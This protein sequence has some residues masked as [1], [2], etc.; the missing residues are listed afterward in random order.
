MVLRNP[1]ANS[2]RH[3]NISLTRVAHKHA[4]PPPTQPTT[5]QCNQPVERKFVPHPL[6]NRSPYQW[7]V[8]RASISSA[9]LA[10]MG[11]RF[12]FIVGVSSSPPGAHGS[13]RT[14]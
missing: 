10:V 5:P 13:L 12:S 3:A 6:T 9:Y 7:S 1:A 11:R 2:G 8:Y 14:W 4:G